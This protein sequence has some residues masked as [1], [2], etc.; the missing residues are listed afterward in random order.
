MFEGHIDP[1]TKQRVVELVGER[2]DVECQLGGVVNVSWEGV[3][4]YWF[5]S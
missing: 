5:A 4:G 1:R 2:C 3:V